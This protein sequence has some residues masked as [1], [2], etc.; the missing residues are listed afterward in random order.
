MPGFRTR[1]W[2][3]RSAFTLMAWAVP[4]RAAMAANHGRGAHA[5]RDLKS[6]LSVAACCFT[7]LGA[8]LAFAIPGCNRGI[9]S[10]EV[11]VYCAVDEP[12]AAQIFAEFEKQTGIR[13]VVQYDIE[14]SKSVGL[15]GKLEAEAEHPRADVWW[16]S[17]A[18]LS[19]RLGEEGA[20]APYQSPAAADIPSQF[21]DANGLW[22]GTALRARVLAVSEKSPP[23]FAITGIRDL[24]DP[25]LKNKIA[26]S[27]PTAGATGAH[28][29][30][31]YSVWGPDKAAAFCR[32]LHANGIALLGGNA[33]VADQ[34]GAG[35]YSLGLTDNDDVTNAAANGGR[36][37]MVVPDQ[38]GEGTLAMPTSVALVKGSKHDASAKKLID[39]LVSK[40]V[41][42]KLIDLKFA[43]WSVRG[44]EDE[45]IKAID[46]DYHVAAKVYARAQREGEA[47]LE[48]R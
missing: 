25:R 18:F 23:P 47:M 4:C 13:T 19:V 8:L 3:I 40:Q 41:E 12:Y 39:F 9:A 21:K 1:R 30:T 48:G 17:E 10:D 42:K 43:R 38:N 6:T 15:A 36:L 46:V 5:T 44:G 14:S 28:L 2:A 7:V 33:E 35:T 32:D 45:A 11:V 34:V 24:A 31:L 16:G 29:A 22:T 26:M 20:L 27:R 37:S